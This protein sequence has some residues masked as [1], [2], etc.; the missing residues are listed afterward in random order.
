MVGIYCAFLDLDKRAMR[1][2]ENMV[3]L[4]VF[5][6][7]ADLTEVM[8]L[9]TNQL[10][11][12]AKGITVM[13]YKNAVPVEDAKTLLN[14]VVVNV[15]DVNADGNYISKKMSVP[16]T[17]KH[18]RLACVLGDAVS[19]AVLGGG[20]STHS[21]YFCRCCF[22][23]QGTVKKNSTVY[24][25]REQLLLHDFCKFLVLYYTIDIARCR[26]EYFAR[27]YDMLRYRFSLM[28][29]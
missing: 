19:Q 1:R 9:I 3:V 14:S 24:E 4:S 23:N 18:P 2:L 8:V 17:K 15:D 16:F 22:C 13:D 26:Y 21:T 27:H 28:C 5:Q 20:R 12:L 11:E 10:R 25:V 29:I 6:K 7:H